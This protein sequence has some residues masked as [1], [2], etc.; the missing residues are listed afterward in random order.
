MQWADLDIA[1]GWWTIPSTQSKNKLSHR[2]PL[3][4][5]A[6]DILKAL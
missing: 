1:G 2:V 5:M 4:P 3:S 6:L